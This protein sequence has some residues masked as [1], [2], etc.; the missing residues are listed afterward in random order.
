MYDLFTYQTYEELLLA[1]Q[2]EEQARRFLA[3]VRWD[4]EPKCLHCG[5]QGKASYCEKRKVFYCSNQGCF[6]QYSVTTGTLFERTHVPLLKWFKAMFEISNGSIASTKLAKKLQV[7]QRTAWKME[8]KIRQSLKDDLDNV[9]LS[10]IVEADTSLF[11]PDLERDFQ[12]KWVV[13]KT[14]K[15]FEKDNDNHRRDRLNKKKRERRHRKKLGLPSPPAGRPKGSKDVKTRLRKGEKR[16][17]QYYKYEKWILGMVERGGKI[18]LQTIGQHATEMDSEEIASIM[19]R[20]IDAGARVITDGGGEFDKVSIFFPGHEKIIHDPWVDF[21]RKDG[22]KGQRQVKKFVDGDKHTNS[23]ESTWAHLK[24]IQWGNHIQI[25]YGHADR[26]LYEFAFHRN[27]RELS[28][29]E[30]FQVMLRSALKM[31]FPYAEFKSYTRVYRLNEK[32][33]EIGHR[34]ALRRAA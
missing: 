21:I 5:H 1:L 33:K 8:Q 15:I 31:T 28:D 7:N 13:K 26:Y 29:A 4:G 12:R 11:T 19:G 2:T 30:K 9:I 24:R 18:Y 16:N 20:K 3:Y 14:Q 34:V 32:G 10:N 22:T 17:N 25:S 27:N 6:K 23:I